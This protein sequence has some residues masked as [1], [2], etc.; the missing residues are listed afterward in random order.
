[1][2]LVPEHGQHDQ[3]LVE[4]TSTSTFAVTQKMALL[5]HYVRSLLCSSICYTMIINIIVI[6]IILIQSSRYLI[7]EHLIHNTSSFDQDIQSRPLLN[8]NP[9]YRSHQMAERAN[10]EIFKKLSFTIYQK[11][12]KSFGTTYHIT[13]LVC[14]MC[15]VQLE[16]NVTSYGHVTLKRQ[17]Y[18]CIKIYSFISKNL[19]SILCT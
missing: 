15:H 5:I 1:M 12:Q 9:S 19:H 6:L 16:Y 13:S 7:R 14:N 18:I 3:S 2:I 10:M 8:Q 4:Y 17:K 11:L